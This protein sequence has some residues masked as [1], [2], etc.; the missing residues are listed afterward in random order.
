MVTHDAAAAESCH[1]IVRLQDGKI[2]GDQ[3]NGG[4]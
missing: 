3:M 1:R 4:K 2:F